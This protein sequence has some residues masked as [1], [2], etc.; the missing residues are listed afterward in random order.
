[1]ANNIQITTQKTILLSYP[2]KEYPGWKVG[3]KI[4]SPL[5]A[6]DGTVYHFPGSAVVQ[7]GRVSGG[8]V[9]V[10]II[11]DPSISPDAPVCV[12]E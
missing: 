4:P 1:M 2:V 6:P 3:E 7:R 8:W 12:I 10:T 5:T 11:H 9:E